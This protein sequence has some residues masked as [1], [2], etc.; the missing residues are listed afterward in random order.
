MEIWTN[1]G[2]GQTADPFAIADRAAELE[3]EGWDGGTVV[4]SE[5]IAVDPYVALT[6]CAE[7]TTKLQLGIGVTNPVTR[8]PAVTAA[9]MATLQIASRGRAQMGIG[10]GDSALAYL[11]ASPVPI[12]RFESVLQMI[13]TYLR[14]DSVSLEEAASLLAGTDTGYDKLTLAKAPPASW[15]KWLPADHK[16]VPMDVAVTGPKAIGIGARVAE[17]ISLV[18]GADVGRLK[19][20]L[21]TAR[22]AAEQAGKDP[23][24]LKTCAFLIVHPHDDVAVARR[25]AAGGISGMSRFLIMNKKVAAPVSAAERQSLERLAQAYDMKTHALGGAQA[26]ALDPE[27]MDSFAIL[28]NSTHC[29]ERLQEIAALGFDRL[30]I[31]TALP[32]LEQGQESHDITVREILPALRR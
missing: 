21:E 27:F 19:W 11:G 24:S 8:H 5:C 29:L 14:G 1:I 15:L 12:G 6:M 20:G 26:E 31:A 22:T 7:R 4:D 30:Q 32:H 10:R 2:G 13:Q 28:G 16:K 3:A 17:R 25:L 18:M 23:A 9:A